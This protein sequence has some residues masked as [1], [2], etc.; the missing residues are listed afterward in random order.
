MKVCSSRRKKIT[1]KQLFV[2][3]VL[4]FLFLGA[5]DLIN[6]FYYF[7]YIATFLFLVIPN[8]KMRFDSSFFVLLVFSTA[9]LMFDPTY[10]TIITSMIKPFTYPL[11][12]LIGTSLFSAGAKE[13]NDLLRDEKR[14]ALVIYTVTGGVLLHFILNRIINHGTLFHGDTGEQYRE[15][16]FAVHI[17]ALGNGAVFGALPRNRDRRDGERRKD[18]LHNPCGADAGA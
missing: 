10:R 9:L 18:H 11:C 4:F 16:H 8:G 14:T 7:I 13:D 3:L 2:F 12:Y 15:F 17:T 1:L 6:R 5:L